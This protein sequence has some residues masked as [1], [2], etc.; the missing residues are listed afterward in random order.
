MHR[1]RKTTFVST[2][3]LLLTSALLPIAAHAQASS[4]GADAIGREDGGL[5][6]IVVTA[7]KRSENLQKVP[8]S[9]AVAT[10]DELTASGVVTVQS[11]K[12]LTPGVEVQGNHGY[13]YPIIRGVGSKANAPGIEPPV[14]TYVDGVYYAAPTG[15]ILT[16]NNIAQVEVLKGPQG[17]LFGRNATG[18]LIQVTTKDPTQELSGKFNISYGNYQ[19]LRGDAYIAGGLSENIAADLAFTGTTMGDGYGKNLTTGKDVYKVDHDINLR[20]KWI[21]TLGEDTSM[22]LIFD[23]ASVHS[24]M[25]ATRVRSGETAPAP[26]GPAYGGG[27]WDVSADTEYFYDAKQ[28]GVSLRLDHEFGSV[29]VASITAYRKVD[30]EGLF[31][32]DYTPTRGRYLSSTQRDWQFSQELQLLSSDQGPIVWSVGAYYFRADASYPFVHVHFAGPAIPPNGAV[33]SDTKSTQGTDSIAGFGQATWEIASGLKITGGL[34]YTSEERSLTNAMT[35][36]TFMNGTSAVTVPLTNVHRRFNKLTYRAA[37]D[38][39]F[40]PDVMGY[41]SYNR[42]FKS[43]GYNP[44]VLTLPP[45]DPEVLDAYEA[46]IK[47]SLWDR[48]VRFNL[49]GFY[50]D[51]NSVQVQRVVNGGTGVANGAKATLYGFETEIEA[52]LSD[53]LSIRVGYQYLHGKYDSFPN[54]I[55]STPRPAGGYSINNAGVATGNRTILSP[56]STFSATVNY[57]VPVGDNE[58]EFNG[59]YYYNSG[60]FHEPDNLLK[61][62]AYSQVNLAAR[63]NM[64]NGFSASVWGNNLTN[65]AVPN[66]EGIQSFGA[67][68]IRRTSFAPP[69]TYGATLGYKF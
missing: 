43:G 45:F 59:T 69:R 7:Q 25:N 34:R 5:G 8:I 22:R 26:F 35:T 64:S 62:P 20:S 11:L 38:Y 37:V 9:V 60:Y 15:S 42:G 17:T 30:Y 21:F 31:D 16:F 14:A 12:M 50:Y 36:V 56:K 63:Y 18:G 6:E 39:Q 54:A 28:G 68:G 65:V 67:T 49:G 47:T 48:R 29:R 52:R 66:I 41:A 33:L 19:T 13:A 57:T 55:V 3:I 10:A 40:S 46:G 53:P 51:Y 58:L 44:N 27:N 24:T 23:Y 4:G 61:M 2:K 1:Q 32:F